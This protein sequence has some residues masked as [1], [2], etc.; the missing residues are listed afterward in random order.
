VVAAVRAEVDAFRLRCQPG[1]SYLDGSWQV[2]A[3]G[4]ARSVGAQVRWS[5]VAA[6]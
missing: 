4:R 1:D 6:V 5:Y 3:G 2:L